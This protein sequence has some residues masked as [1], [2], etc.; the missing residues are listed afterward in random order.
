MIDLHF[1]NSKKT[2]LGVELELLLI[3]TKTYLPVNKSDQIAARIAPEFSPYIHTEFFQ[4]MLEISSP[5][6]EHVD[7]IKP[8]F[9]SVFDHI[10]TIGKS[11]GITA[12]AT[13]THPL[14]FEKD[15]LI[16]EK[17]RYGKLHNELKNVLDRFLIMGLH[18]HVGMKNP[19]HAV[20]A[21]NMVNRLMPI[22]LSM[23]TS[24]PFFEGKDTGLH[25]CRSKIF[26]S[27]PRG[28]I[29]EFICN[30]NHFTVMIELLAKQNIIEA[31]NDIWWDVRIRPDFGTLEL[32]VCDAVNDIERIQAIAAFYQ[33]VC[34]LAE[35]ES[36]KYFFH[37]ISKQNKWTAVRYGFDGNFIDVGG[38]TTI[39]DMATNKLKQ[40]VQYDIFNRLQTESYIE[41]IQ[42]YLTIPSISAKTRLL[43]EQTNDFVPVIKEGVIYTQ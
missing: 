25:S 9:N 30:Y 15:P 2:T 21:C 17:E 24:S 18:V 6:F 29:P 16:T 11:L 10:L 33:A 3:D 28:G 40:L 7:D 1:N 36:Q 23:S 26:E 31:Y 38:S 32:R 27:L 43:Y 14:L 22:F 8:F 4:N 34:S 12:V 41:L 5:I 13:G 19:A 20:N 35:T 42:H 37:Q 39:Q